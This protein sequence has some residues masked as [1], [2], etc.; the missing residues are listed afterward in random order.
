MN[1]DFP[2]PSRRM[3][4]L[5]RN[6]V[7]TAQPLAA[8]AGLSMLAKG[9]NAVDA[10][11]ATAITLTIVE[12][13]SN[14]IG[15]DAFA[16]VWD[17][18]ELSG[19][20]ASGRSPA[21]W[22][23]DRF[24]GAAMPH[25]GWN[26]AT[27]PGAP[28]AWVALSLRFGRLP[29]ADL[30][31][32][33]IRNARD[34]FLVSP[35]IA[36]IWGNQV[37][38]LGSQ[39]GFAETF[40]PHGRAPSAGEHFSAPNHAKTLQSIAETKAESFYRGEIAATIARASASA[41]AHMSADDLAAHRVEWTP[42]IDVAF[43]GYRVHELP[44]NGQ[45]IAAL[46]ALGILDRL[47]LENLASD[48]PEMLHLQIEALK[49]GTADVR[50]HV[51]DPD[52]MTVTPDELLDPARLEEFSRSIDRDRVAVPAP[53]SMNRG[54]TVYLTAA[55]QDGMM[56]SLIQSNYHGFGSGI[57][58]PGTGIALNNRGSCFVT[59]AGH[60]NRVAPSKRP[61]NTIIPGF[62]TKDGA[63]F[64]S[65]GVMGGTMQPQ[66]HTQV[67]SRMLLSGQNPQ[68][69]IDA[70]RWRVEG[71]EVWVEAALSPEARRGLTSRGHKLR[72]GTLLEFGAAQI[73]QRV[74][75]GYIAGSEGR[76]DGCAVGF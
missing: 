11:I 55:D 12:P 2:Y 75:H 60:P 48:S 56:V 46:I 72:D 51:A 16:I 3:P 20:N 69:A 76:R 58:V 4:V 57:V 64:A 34:G 36:M 30:F 61:L 1:W 38:R 33:A 21:G 49:I 28:S 50:A 63:P 37:E 59:K 27:V 54:A 31:E 5:A 52:F 17:G 29:F 47:D 74:E 65:F 62:I 42:P 45:G 41:G 71:D 8:Q 7:A 14:G 15:S 53:R 13:C 26:S 10:A 66:G 19:L 39:P 24:T 67:A 23:P 9:G 70:P 40:L 73:I 35:T 22:T 6:I 68:A 18:K 32:P 43:R 44:P 25:E